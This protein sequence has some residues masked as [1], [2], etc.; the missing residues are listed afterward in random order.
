VFQLLQAIYVKW[1]T[2]GGGDKLVATTTYGINI[3]FLVHYNIWLQGGH[4]VMT[5]SCVL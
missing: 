1:K 3:A 4:D 2:F 5:L